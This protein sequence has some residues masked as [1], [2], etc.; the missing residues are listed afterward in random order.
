MVATSSLPLAVTKKNISSVA[1][2]ERHGFEPCK[3]LGG[4]SRFGNCFSSSFLATFGFAYLPTTTWY[5]FVLSSRS[6]CFSCF[7]A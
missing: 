7:G 6:S 1:W 3:P 4:V 2:K 5:D